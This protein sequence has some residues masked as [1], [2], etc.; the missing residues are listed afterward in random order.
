MSAVAPGVLVAPTPAAT[1]SAESEQPANTT[2]AWSLRFQSVVKLLPV[3][4]PVAFP[5]TDQGTA[6]GSVVVLPMMRNKQSPLGGG[7]PWGGGVSNVM[8]VTRP[9]THS[10]R[11]ELIMNLTGPLDAQVTPKT[12]SRVFPLADRPFTVRPLLKKQP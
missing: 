8:P 4:I 5:L 7:S 2:D 1:V 6:L 10:K 11:H 3:Q 9:A 12:R